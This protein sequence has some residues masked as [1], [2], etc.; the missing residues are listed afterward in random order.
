[1]H[2]VDGAC[3]IDGG[4]L[5]SKTIFTALFVFLLVGQR[6]SSIQCIALA[7][8]FGLHVMYSAVCILV[9]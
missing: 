6:Q 3:S 4:H 1:M 7:L 5:Q 9:K 8:L 2:Y